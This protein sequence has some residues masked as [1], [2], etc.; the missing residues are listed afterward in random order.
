MVTIPQMIDIEIRAIDSSSP[1]LA[2][3]IK[4]HRADSHRLG[5]FPKGAFED[6]ARA[7]QIL[8]ALNQGSEVLGYLL[9]RVA[10][11]RAIIVHLCT[12]PGARGKG[13]ARALVEDLKR[14]SKPL[15][16]IGLRC[17]QD[18]DMKYVWAKF[19]FTAVD[20]KAGRSQ[21]G[22]ELT[23]WWFDHGHPDLFSL[24]QSADEHRQKVV[25]DANVFFDLQGPDLR[26]SEDS[27]ALLAD[28]VQANIELCV[29]K[30]I[31]N[32]I[33]RGGD[34]KLRARSKAAATRYATVRS[35][36]TVFQRVC[37]DLKAWFP[38]DAVLRDE[39]DLRQIAY[40]IAGEVAYFVTRDEEL[41]ER[42]EPLYERYGLRVLHPAE[43]ISGLD[44][45]ER[46]AQYR[47]SRIEGSRLRSRSITADEVET[48]VEAFRNAA[49]EKA[50][51][52]RKTLLHC[53][54][55]PRDIEARLVTDHD[56]RP[57]IFGVCDRS[58]VAV[59]E[60][61]MLRGAEHTLAATMIRNFLRSTLEAATKEKRSII[62]V[63]DKC[64]GEMVREALA[65]FAFAEFDDGW[66]KIAVRAVG[67]L[68][69]LREMVRQSATEEI[70]GSLA[71]AAQQALE[72]AVAPNDAA[73]VAAV[74]SRFWPA[75]VMGAGLPT[76]IISIRAEWAQHFFDND[77][78]AQLLFRSREELLLG[79]EGVYYCS[80]KH[81]HLTAPARILWYV[82]R[83]SKGDGSMTIK[84]CSRL[85]EVVI[86]KPKELFKRFRRL[87]IFEWKDVFDTANN[88]L[89]NDILAF[90]F[91]MTERFTQPFTLDRL[92]AIGIRQPLLG[93]RRISDEQ[94]AT[95]YS[96]GC[97][98]S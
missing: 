72:T 45:I 85:E 57:V 69:S 92:E 80:A 78:A 82:S 46:E 5:F 3:V 90:R 35:D 28:W 43:L 81:R 12:A 32:E 30:E 10:K 52:F 93:P 39:S 4:L 74:E 55:K 97:A 60:I 54:G 58:N 83:G 1:H 76:F 61:S 84:A 71:G 42:C 44:V 37:D 41:A 24:A 77:L 50:N 14:L 53:L 15:A 62:K 48:V 73:T 87:G 27:K 79:I 7:R 88:D 56:N 67:D 23:F 25:V 59:L 29:T 49:Q 36:D 40:A 26:D 19:G 94:F 51:P 66:A 33:D 47:P 63:S 6:H 89:T 20:R 91:S 31:L 64:A 2:D 70:D 16:G 21:D 86:G 17:R 13:V 75:K 68:A 8:L 9:Y 11:Q 38:K 98:L 95:I 34:A 96:Y 22:H 65:E 18:Y